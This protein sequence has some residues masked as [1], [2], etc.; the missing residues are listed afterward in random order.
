MLC[1]CNKL[2]EPPGISGA[3]AASAPFAGHN[4]FPNYPFTA[5]S[6]QVDQSP[7]RIRLR[8]RV[9]RNFGDPNTKES[10]E[11]FGIRQEPRL[12]ST[13]G[14]AKV[15]S[16]SRIWKHV[17]DEIRRAV[18]IL[19]QIYCHQPGSKACGLVVTGKAFEQNPFAFFAIYRPAGQSHVFEDAA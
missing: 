15:H 3:N 2:D 18:G 6:G 7:F 13:N 10:S 14:H 12:D 9:G 16:I 11:T 5:L 17:P 8:I 1:C 4:V 19:V